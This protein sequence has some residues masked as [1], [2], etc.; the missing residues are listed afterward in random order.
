MRKFTQPIWLSSLLFFSFVSTNDANEKIDF[1]KSIAPIFEKHCV[2]CH[3]SGNRKGDISLTTSGDLEENEYVIDGDPDGSYLIELVTSQNGEPPEM[4][5]KGER[6]HEDEVAVLRRWV[7]EGA[8]WPDSVVVKEKPRAGDD[9]WSLQSIA[10]KSE[11]SIDDLIE[12]RLRTAGLSLS[13]PAPRKALIHRAYYDLIGLPPTPEEVRA[14]VEDPNPLAFE[15]VVDRLLDS[16]HYGE[17]WGRHWLDVIR[18]GES[19]GYERNVIVDN[20]WPFRDY[21]IRSINQDKSFHQFIREHLAG[22]VIGPGDPDVAIGSAFLVAGPYDDVGNQD[23]A[24][25]A[26]IR[27]NTLDE[28]IR[29]TSEAFLGLT[30]GCARCHDHKFDPITQ[31]DYYGLYATF[32]G[33]RHGEQTLATPEEIV[34]RE[35][36]LKPLLDQKQAVDQNLI[37]HREARLARAKSRLDELEA[38]WTRPPVD[39]TGTEERFPPVEAKFVRLTC[40]AQDVKPATDTGFGID[41]FQVWSVGTS[42]GLQA[43]ASKNV[44]LAMNGGQASG[45]ARP[46]EDF[47]EAYSAQLAIDGKRGARFIAADNKLT[48]ELAEPTM[49]DRV[50]FSNVQSKQDNNGWRFAFVADY[51]I[52]VSGDGQ[53]WQE[54]ANGRDRQPVNRESH[55][56]YR[57]LKM[58]LTIEDQLEQSRL[59]NELREVKVKVGQVP[60][61]PSVWMGKRVADDAKGPFHVFLGGNP[62]KRGEEVVPAS[63][64]VLSNDK[65]ADEKGNR[66]RLQPDTQEDQRRLA[67]ADWLVDVDN[68]L[69][70]R[71]LANRVWQY[72]FGTGIVD[73]PSDF[74]YMGSKPSHPELLDFLAVKLRDNDWRLKDLHRLIMNS[75]VYQQ[76]SRHRTE[77]AQIDASTRLLWR[78]PPR[79]L[80]A[81]E[82]RDTILQVSGKLDAERGGPGFRLYHYMQD[83]VCTYVPLDQH[84]PETYRRAVYH[85][86]AR[87]SVVDLMTDFDQPD[88]TFSS[89]KR[90]ETTTPLQALTMLNH[91]FTMDMA[92]AFANRLR[93]DAGDSPK[94]QL[95]RAFQLCF[96]RE[97]AEDEIAPCLQI[98]ENYGLPAMCRILLN[99]SE[100]IYVR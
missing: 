24:Q 52:E 63:L 2:S 39:R 48:I 89:P 26:Q 23:A 42:P 27:A 59:E 82:I 38:Q 33:I 28:M 45:K 95:Q 5:K 62:Q 88:C 37:D 34:A 99:T 9:W 35:R 54:V 46:N 29:A 97:P 96:S 90:A 66:Y 85:Q 67:L 47:P 61:L 22:D 76:S 13:P 3:S 77:A 10:V 6:L 93:R 41:E 72:H 31:Q 83:N 86:N 69:T 68:P 12:Q 30:I 74:G 75:R 50:V 25:A 19:I 60:N 1:A 64:Q 58:D 98:V 40:E 51:R 80:S 53:N 65:T 44:A 92:N 7:L 18:F 56:N 78:F 71:V 94:A 84:G 32:A 11:T 91:S 4:P 73:T 43:V 55:L 70:L 21:V 57:L 81:E 79:R 15:V 100:L 14:F 49:I 20:L 17:R 16:P 8:E 36:T 87:A